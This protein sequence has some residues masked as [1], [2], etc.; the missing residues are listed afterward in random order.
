LGPA[1]LFQSEAGP[2]EKSPGMSEANQGFCED[3]LLTAGN[4]AEIFSVRSGSQRKK[5]WDERSESWL[6]CSTVPFSG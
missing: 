6:L 1:G 2:K 5:S 3:P 4:P